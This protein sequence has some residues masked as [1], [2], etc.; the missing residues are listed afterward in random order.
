MSN[1][2]DTTQGLKTSDLIQNICNTVPNLPSFEELKDVM[3]ENLL[4]PFIEKSEM[5]TFI[6]K[7]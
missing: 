7:S 2:Y 5:D 1:N 3:Y 6:D 4:D